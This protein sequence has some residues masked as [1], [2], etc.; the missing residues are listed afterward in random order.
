VTVG[1]ARILWGGDII[2]A[3]NDQP[4]ASLQELT[5]YL[6]SE[7]QVGDTVQVTVVRDGEETTMPLTLAERPQ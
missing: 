7:T 3:L 5:V 1:N 2:V 6:E 4:V